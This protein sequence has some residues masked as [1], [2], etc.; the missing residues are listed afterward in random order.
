M[1]KPQRLR[2]LFLVSALIV[3]IEMSACAM[4]R[5]SVRWG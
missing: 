3:A 1:T 4:V 2:W 5:S